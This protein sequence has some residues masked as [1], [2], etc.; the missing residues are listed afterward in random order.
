M[1]TDTQPSVIEDD[2]NDVLNKAIIGTGT[3][4]Q[5]LCSELD[6]LELCLDGNMD[7]S[8]VLQIAPKLN[9]T[10]E[11][12]LKHPSYYPNTP[13]PASCHLF[14]SPFGY[15]GV[16]S[17]VIETQSHLL[18]F[19]TGTDATACTEFIKN[20]PDKQALLFITHEHAD[21]IACLDALKPLTG[22][23]LI[24][25][26]NSQHQYD[27]ITLTVI[28]V[29]GH[30]S[31]AQA[32]YITGLDSPLC[33]VG[34]AIFAGSIGKCQPQNYQTALSNIRNNLL[35]LPGETILFPGHGPLTTVALEKE[36]NPFF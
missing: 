16:N 36:N 22:D 21:H 2:F 23:P 30:L 12:L 31:P 8:L 24:L 9:L 18:I 4:K 11:K 29:A 10:P 32:F 14:V 19:D 13:I 28:D 26:L 17:Y 27:N 25:D 33:M 5:Q 1:A 7:E 34:D 35:T 20:H 6:R 3:S 15:I